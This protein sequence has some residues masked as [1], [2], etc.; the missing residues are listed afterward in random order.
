MNDQPFWRTI[1]LDAMS[2]AQWESLCDGCGKCCLFKLEDEDTG[3]V[4]YTEVAC[5]YLND[6]CRCSSYTD[7]LTKVESCLRLTPAALS[8][9]D[10][11]PGT[12]AY[13]L[14]AEGRDL[15]QWHPLVT[16]NANSTLEA[17]MSVRNRTVS[18][19]AIDLDDLEDYIV[20]WPH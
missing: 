9:V 4:F 1:A 18:E 19:T 3:E 16:G 10:W 5:R 15:P 17:G 7:R 13:R 20:R 2:E 6:H 11:L 14:L 8:T 12:C